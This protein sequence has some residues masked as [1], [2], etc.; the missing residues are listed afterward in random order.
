MFKSLAAR[1]TAAK[2][3]LQ[4]KLEREEGLET[5][6]KLVITAIVVVLAVGVFL[7]I[8]QIVSNQASETG[9]AITNSDTNVPL[10]V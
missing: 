6:E 10:P 2:W 4:E 9:D 7:F 8:A 3:S 1:V 5:A